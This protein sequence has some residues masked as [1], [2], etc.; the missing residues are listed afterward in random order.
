MLFSVVWREYVLNNAKIANRL[1]KSG[2]FKV[3]AKATRRYNRWWSPFVSVSLVAVGWVTGAVN[4]KCTELLWS[5]HSG[6]CYAIKPCTLR[7]GNTCPLSFKNSNLIPC[8]NS[9]CR[10]VYSSAFQWMTEERGPLFKNLA[11]K[12]SFTWNG[13]GKLEALTV[14]TWFIA[15]FSQSLWKL[16][17]QMSL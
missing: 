11:S 15:W 3:E 13:F 6:R 14:Y 5:Y 7:E 1:V 8:V 17:T 4:E 2:L 12:H 16:Q 10:H 9:V